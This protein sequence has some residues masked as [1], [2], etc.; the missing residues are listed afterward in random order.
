MKAK[1]KADP[2]ARRDRE[3]V[4]QPPLLITSLTTDVD[5]ITIAGYK[6]GIVETLLKQRTLQKKCLLLAGTLF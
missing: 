6:P 5:F 4:I 3:G 2:S 1:F